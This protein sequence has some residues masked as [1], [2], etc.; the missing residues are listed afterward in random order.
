[1]NN[2]MKSPI[3]RQIAKKMHVTNSN[4]ISNFQYERI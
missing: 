2:N 4:V 1:M 3:K